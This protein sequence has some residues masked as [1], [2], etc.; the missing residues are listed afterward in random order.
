MR[1][2]I[3]DDDERRAAALA[4]HISQNV[5]LDREQ[6]STSSD[7]S[8]ASEMLKKAYFDVLIIDVILPRRAN[9]RP[10]AQNGINL[11][12]A[13]E[14]GRGLRKPGRIL[15]ITA[16]SSDIGIYREEFSKSCVS[17][18]EAASGDMAW[19]DVI[20]NSINYARAAS[21]SRSV[22]MDAT[23]VITVHGIQTFGGWQKRL[24]RI[25][26]EAAG[27]VRFH[28]YKYG[29]YSFFAFLIPP[30][31]ARE[32][33][34]LKQS[35]A[36]KFRRNPDKRFV[37][38]CHS[39]GTY[40]VHSAVAKL[41]MEKSS[42]Q[43]PIHTIVLSGSVL[44]HR[45]DWSAFSDKRIR[46]VND[47]ADHD[48]VLYLSQYLVWGVGM[49]G[50]CGFY[51]FNGASMVNRYFN[52]GHSSYFCGD[53]FML[54]YWV[55]LISASDRPVPSIDMRSQSFLRHSIFDKLA[56]LLGKFTTLSINATVAL[57]IPVAIL[58]ATV[59]LH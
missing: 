4:S 20:S 46:I 17:V 48:Y 57:L 53:S 31:R 6:I 22:E 12:R 38:F 23:E 39:F 27:D 8:D 51:G 34:K 5:G 50:R 41:L 9:D 33:D 3:I 14:R 15:G 43:V 35:L 47:C 11:L 25:A 13:L 10:S 1:I 32:S 30:L 56:L 59:R 29:L 45:T 26:N 28:T 24:E 18:V 49:A 42:S 54:R 55:P 19:R 21:V 36:E 52:G 40:L 37:V 58:V 44:K 2:L 16:N 7:T